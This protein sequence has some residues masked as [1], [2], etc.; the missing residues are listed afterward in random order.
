VQ[1]GELISGRYRIVRPIGRGASATTHE[2]E[3]VSTGVRVALKELK[4]SEM[5]R[6][7]ELEL[8]SREAETLSRIRH[9]CIPRYIEHFEVESERG[10]SYVLVQELVVGSSLEER[11]SQGWVPTEQ[12][13]VR[14]AVQ[15]LET[16]AYLQTL[17]PPIVHRDIKPANLLWT[18][19]GQIA[20]VD[21][22]AALVRPYAEAG[23]T[24]AGT[25]GYMAPEQLR[26]LADARSDLYALG[27]SL[28]FLLTGHRPDQLPVR[29]LRIDV[30]SVVTVQP[31]FAEFLMRLVEPA[32]ED[33]Y[34]SPVEALNA[35]QSPARRGFSK[36]QILAFGAA[37][38]LIPAFV[39][40]FEPPQRTPATNFSHRP[41]AG[42][43]VGDAMHEV[44]R[45][46]PSIARKQQA[47]KEEL[48]NYCA[49]SP[50]GSKSTRMRISWGAQP[51]DPE[52]S[53]EN[54]L[55]CK[56]FGCIGL[57]QNL[58]TYY[59]YACTTVPAS[60]G[61]PPEF[62][63][64]ASADLDGD[65]ISKIFVFGSANGEAADGKIVSPIPRIGD[66]GR[67]REGKTPANRLVDC[68]PNEL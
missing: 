1:P 36:Q 68:D 54:P 67:C 32:P 18:E 38:F 14:I 12:D 55:A 62:T 51:C 66:L 63:C 60:E 19:E 21:F 13:A 25:F 5:R 42:Q 15:L 58:V 29:R 47:F 65:A 40:V 4:L 10:A 37:A 41:E 46:L 27:A 33:R 53:S 11:I 50:A 35:L 26:G 49:A 44:H 2:A 43:I 31:S 45:M 24:V 22:G 20:L 3:L 39:S 17:R 34:A 7:K 48:G 23:N 64:A 59:R 30:R 6:W 28:L 52:C 9:P 56:T 61:A 57:D 8:L 16:L